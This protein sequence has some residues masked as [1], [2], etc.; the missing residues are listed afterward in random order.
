MILPEAAFPHAKLKTHRLNR[1]L[2]K[3]VRDRLS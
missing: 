3:S 2:E 1:L